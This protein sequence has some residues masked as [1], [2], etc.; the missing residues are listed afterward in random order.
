MKK[1]IDNEKAMKLLQV[2]DKVDFESDEMVIEGKLD[3][4]GKITASNGVELAE[5]TILTVPSASNVFIKDE[6]T[7]LDQELYAKQDKLV[8]GTNIKTING[9]S[10]LGSGNIEISGGGDDTW[11][12]N[13]TSVGDTFNVDGDTISS[14]SNYFHVNDLEGAS[15]ISAEAGVD[16]GIFLETSGANGLQ[17][18]TLDEGSILMTA[19]TDI[20]FGNEGQESKISLSD[21]ITMRTKISGSAP[22]TLLRLKM[23]STN[24]GDYFYVYMENLSNLTD[25][26]QKYYF[27]T[28]FKSYLTGPDSATTNINTMIAWINAN[29]GSF[30]SSQKNGLIKWLVNMRLFGG[31]PAFAQYKYLNGDGGEVENCPVTT[32]GYTA[33]ANA[34]NV[35]DDGTISAN[36]FSINLL[37]ENATYFELTRTDETY[38]Q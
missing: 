6:S 38:I 20:Y 31:Q 1:M 35:A 16:G 7:S 15:L 34:Y 26:L 14:H 28:S 27:A 33:I 13:I 5:G 4:N 3:V 25:V 21:I 9:N 24:E 17:L 29:Q 19:A 12:E 37:A 36:P 11:K 10:M 2:A 23:T 8:S 18:T 22:Y 32:K 30:T